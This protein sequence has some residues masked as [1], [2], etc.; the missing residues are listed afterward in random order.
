MAKN[1]NSWSRPRGSA[2]AG[3]E[4]E[5]S[6][7]L[8]SEPKNSQS[9]CRLQCSGQMPT[10]SRARKM[11]RLLKSMSAMA[12]WPRSVLEDALAVFLVEVDDDL[13][14][15][16][17]AEHVALGLQFRLAL[18]IVEQLAVV[19]DGDALI[20]VEDRLL[21]VAETDDGKPAVGEAEAGAQ[22]ESVVVGAAMPERLR[23]RVQRGGIGLALAGEVNDSSD[24]AHRSSSFRQQRLG[25]GCSPQWLGKGPVTQRRKGRHCGNA[26]R[27]QLKSL[28]ALRLAS[29]A[30]MRRSDFRLA[31][32][33]R[34]TIM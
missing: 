26:L 15:G 30:Q 18:G 1:V 25:S 21:A 20:L 9:P 33:S 4:P 5:A 24:A 7:A 29:R 32:P 27:R 19:D 16:V 2:R 11:V 34:P 6:S 3:T 13:G 17:R 12:N 14:V 31:C 23:H 22:Q 28:S 10:R 8:I